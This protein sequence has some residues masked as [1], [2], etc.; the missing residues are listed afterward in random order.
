MNKQKQL[1]KDFFND[2]SREWFER[3]YDPAEQ[4]LKFPGNRARMEIALSEIKNLSVKGAFLD[5]GCGTGQLV[6]ELLKKGVRATGI[7][8]AEKMIEIAK[9]NLAKE[10]LSFNPNPNEIFAVMDLAELG[11]TTAH[12]DAVTALGLLEYLSKDD[13]LFSVLKKNV[14]KDGYA[15]V[16]CRNKF[17]NLF[18]V[19]NYTESTAKTKMLAPLIREMAEVDKY[20]PI[21]SRN[22][23]AIQAEVSQKIADFLK[24]SAGKSEWLET[25]I[26]KHLDYPQEMIRRQHTPKELEASAHRFGFTLKY[27]VYWHAH[28][29]PPSFKKEFPRIYN[30]I[31]FLEA[32]L[33]YTSLGAWMCSSFV[34]VLKKQE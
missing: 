6:I 3:T 23:P 21:S 4:F 12:Y 13:E 34:A 22:I 17:F 5:I 1:T 2:A 29:Y 18:S 30:K 9:N 24:E 11:K 14:K 31:S 15:F 7:D 25:S 26:P 33:G 8:V 20:S 16:E 27:V 32:P 10:K 28:L 19:N